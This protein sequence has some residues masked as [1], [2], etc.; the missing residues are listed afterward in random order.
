MTTSE[1]VNEVE[2]KL[3]KHWLKC[4]V[5]KNRIQSF[6]LENRNRCLE[7]SAKELLHGL[8]HELGLEPG[9]WYLEILNIQKA[10]RTD[11]EKSRVFEKVI[12]PFLQ[13]S[14]TRVIELLVT[15]RWLFYISDIINC[16]YQADLLRCRYLMQDT[17]VTIWRQ[18]RQV[19][20]PL[21]DELIEKCHDLR[22]WI[23]WGIF[24]DRKKEKWNNYQPKLCRH[25]ENASKSGTSTL[26]VSIKGQ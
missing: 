26:S 13:T 7:T 5:D 4:G 19:N 18:Y 22:P 15:R 24:L 20:I 1:N 17:Q 3:F 11:Y 10:P 25:I 2:F 6:L 8:L 14:P 9:D 12:I 21:S 23:E 16:G